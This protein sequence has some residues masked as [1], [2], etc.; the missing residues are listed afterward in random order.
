MYGYCC[1]FMRWV[2]L[3]RFAIFWVSTEPYLVEV[4]LSVASLWAAFVLFEPPSNFAAY[5]ISFALVESIQGQESAWAVMALVGAILKITGLA[6]RLLLPTR[7]TVT[8]YLMRSMGLAISGF[9]WMLMGA[10]ALVGNPDSIFPIWGPLTALAA[11]RTLVKFLL[12][13]GVA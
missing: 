8:A 13:P 1:R 2:G 3:T 5:P 12:K 4:Y 7:M 10:S 9:F 6:I 11:W